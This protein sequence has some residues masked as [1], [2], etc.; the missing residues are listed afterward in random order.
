MD[1]FD[2]KKNTVTSF[3]IIKTFTEK[4]FNF[5][6]HKI[7]WATGG[8]NRELWVSGFIFTIIFMQHRC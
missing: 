3:A 7:E 5:I 4:H 2:V 6:D 8:K 1:I